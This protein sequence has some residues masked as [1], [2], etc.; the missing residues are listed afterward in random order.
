M[1]VKIHL[2]CFHNDKTP[3]N[4]LLKYCSSVNYYARK[5][6]LRGFSWNTPYIVQSRSDEQLLKNLQA[7]DHPILIEGIH[8]SY[9]LYHNKLPGRKIIVRL[10]NVEWKYYQQLARHESNL[11]KKLYFFF[12][13]RLLKKYEQAIAGKAPFL[14]VSTEDAEIYGK[15]FNAKQ[16]DF[17]PVFLPWYEVTSK[18]GK[19]CFCLYHGNL[20]VNENEK[21]AKWLL[22]N[23]FNTL[24]IPFV[25]AGRN[26]SKA[27]QAMA[28][29]HAHTC[30]AANPS[31][32]ELQDLIK[33]AQVNILPS[34]NKTGVKLKLLNALYNGRHCL[35]N[36]AGDE[37]SGLE[38][39][40]V[41]ANNDHS[42]RE[43]IK[44]LFEESF[45]EEQAAKRNSTLHALYNNEENARRLMTWIY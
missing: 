7:D 14:A 12:E 10:H 39:L 24:E 36:D 4:E 40:S 23:I 19:G 27:L 3:Q 11:L 17:I 20:A 31:D 6:N 35:V 33:K 1:G 9:L 37:G 18:T 43:Q 30:M 26:P 22:S 25:I 34:F 41:H 8:C 13:S 44:K 2:H 21:A 32:A 29:A 28:H 45:T 38:S 16:V 42:F 15:I 5:K